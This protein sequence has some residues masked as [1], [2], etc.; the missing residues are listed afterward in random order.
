MD[1]MVIEYKFIKQ[2]CSILSNLI[3][4]SS[5]LMMILHFLTICQARQSKKVDS[6]MDDGYSPS[7]V[8]LSIKSSHEAEPN[9]IRRNYSFTKSRDDAYFKLPKN[10]NDEEAVSG[11]KKRKHHKGTKHH[12]K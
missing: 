10:M 6:D 8:L 3:L 9:K 5:T 2:N 1:A 7:R 11:N 4:A 12:K